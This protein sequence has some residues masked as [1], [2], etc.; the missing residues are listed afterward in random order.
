MEVGYFEGQNTSIFQKFEN[1]I[2]TMASHLAPCGGQIS[3]QKFMKHWILAVNR[4]S[5]LVHEIK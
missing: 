2:M 5:Y 1:E 3:F 4:Q